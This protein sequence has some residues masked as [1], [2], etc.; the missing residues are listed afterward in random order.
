M[1]IEANKTLVHRLY[2]EV[3]NRGTLSTVDELL[4][5]DY[6]D[7]TAFPGTAPGPEGLKQFISLFRTAFPD[8][9]MGISP[10][11]KQV[12]ITSIDT[13][14]FAGG[15]LVEHWGSTDSLGLL[16]QL[17]VIPALGPAR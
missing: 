5:A 14:C 16:Q 10:T 15:K 4:A 7:H 12:T 6:V 8:L 1:S 17:G 3:F 11:G 2:E 9:H 13:G